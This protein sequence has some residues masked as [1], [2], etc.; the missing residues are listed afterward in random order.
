MALLA[1]LLVDVVVV[2]LARRKREAQIEA[3]EEEEGSSELD[4]VDRAQRDETRA[5]KGMRWGALWLRMTMFSSWVLRVI[6]TS[7]GCCLSNYS[8]F[9]DHDRAEFRTRVELFPSIIILYIAQ[10][11][12]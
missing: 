2:Q 5:R 11:T 6:L 1:L 3:E 8:L 12:L 9:Y 10:S 4:C 7:S